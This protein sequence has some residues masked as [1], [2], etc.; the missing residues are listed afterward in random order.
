MILAWQ[1]FS[2]HEGLED[3]KAAD[4]HPCVYAQSKRTAY[5]GVW[6]GLKEEAGNDWQCYIEVA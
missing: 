4:F 3:I 2:L 1:R 6:M 5:I